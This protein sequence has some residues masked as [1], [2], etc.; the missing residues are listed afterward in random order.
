MTT[1]VSRISL[2]TYNE[3]YPSDDSDDS[4]ELDTSFTK[5]NHNLDDDESDSSSSDYSSVRS[6]PNILFNETIN[7]DNEESWSSLSEDGSDEDMPNIVQDQDLVNDESSVTD[8]SEESSD[9]DD[10]ELKYHV[11]PDSIKVSLDLESVELLVNLIKAETKANY[12]LHKEQ[13]KSLLCSWIGVPL[14]TVI[15]YTFIGFTIGSMYR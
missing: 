14:F 9:E 1:P 2:R 12:K 3:K 8:S 11:N 7:D 4:G 10:S 6:R 5:I 13:S 15:L